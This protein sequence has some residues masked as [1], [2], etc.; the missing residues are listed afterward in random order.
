MDWDNYFVG[1]AIV[2]LIFLFCV[3]LVIFAPKSQN[4]FKGVEPTLENLVKNK[5][6]VRDTFVRL[7]IKLSDDNLSEEYEAHYKTV[8]INELT[9]RQ[10]PETQV[11]NG[12]VE[13][14]PI[15]MFSK[16]DDENYGIFNKLF[17]EISHLDTMQS[18]FFL[19]IKS[20][21][22]LNKHK[23][24]A[25]LT[26]KTLRFIYCFNSFCYSEDDCGIWVNGEAKKL[27]KDYSYIFDASKE[28]SIY[29]NTF[30][31]VVFLIIDFDRPQSIP[32]GYS[33]NNFLTGIHSE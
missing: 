24:W 30:D 5:D 11:V 6:I 21:S 12:I 3:L 31:D 27:F 20:K 29:N 14:L 25:D 10:W 9:W 23:G 1:V 13:Y 15:Y 8:K 19:K 28:H 17:S 18:V 16:I 2:L 32:A 7:N 22:G 4:F 26:N 33:Y